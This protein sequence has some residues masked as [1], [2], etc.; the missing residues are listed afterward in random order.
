M[1]KILK[2]ITF[3]YKNSLKV[4]FL[5][6]LSTFATAMTF[7]V[8]C[9]ATSEAVLG[10]QTTVP[11]I[12]LVKMQKRFDGPAGSIQQDYVNTVDSCKRDAGKSGLMIGSNQVVSC[13]T[14]ASCMARNAYTEA[15]YGKY[16]PENLGIEFFCYVE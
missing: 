11:T 3:D 1:L 7:L 6:K 16:D 15:P 12:Q 10:K 2:C 14:F 9:S 8:S 13:N 4:H 5:V